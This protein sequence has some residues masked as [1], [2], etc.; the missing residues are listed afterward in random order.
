MAGPRLALFGRQPD[1]LHRYPRWEATIFRYMSAETRPIAKAMQRLL[2][3]V[4][5]TVAELCKPENII[6]ARHEGIRRSLDGLLCPEG[7]DHPFNE[8]AELAATGRLFARNADALAHEHPKFAN[9]NFGTLGKLG[10]LNSELG[11]MLRAVMTP[12]PT[13]KNLPVRSIGP[14]RATRSVYIPTPAEQTQLNVR[15]PELGNH[16]QIPRKSA[17]IANEVHIVTGDDDNAYVVKPGP[18]AAREVATYR[19]A[20]R[21]DAAWRAAMPE[22]LRSEVRDLVPVTTFVRLREGEPPGSMQR[23]VAHSP[24]RLPLH[25][26]PSLQVTRAGICDWSV[27]SVDRH[28]GNWGLLDHPDIALWDNESTFPVNEYNSYFGNFHFYCSGVVVN[29][30]F[31]SF[32]DQEELLAAL[33][34][35]GLS[36]PAIHGGFNRLNNVIDYCRIPP[37]ETG[38]TFKIFSSS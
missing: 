27:G 13:R 15:L 9:R 18:L 2:H 5:K 3:R 35:T 38:N 32:L 17:K 19:F 6:F 33:S 21:L 1:L 34:D 36:D 7:G 31:L 22:E 8:V 26:L 24:Y 10:D 16:T 11:S 4:D 23:F 29:A 28:S 20:S 30:E 25:Y 37:P 12:R 14:V